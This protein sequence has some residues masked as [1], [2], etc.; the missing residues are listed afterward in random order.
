MLLNLLTSKH[1]FENK[2][3]HMHYFRVD[4]CMH[5]KFLY[6]S[7]LGTG[8]ALSLCYNLILLYALYKISFEIALRCFSDRFTLWILI[9]EVHHGC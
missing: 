8:K 6:V 1:L 9:H 3:I 5:R 4:I 2:Q 7:T